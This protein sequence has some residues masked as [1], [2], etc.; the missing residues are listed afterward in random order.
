MDTAD[1]R[2]RELARE[3][4]AKGYPSPRGTGWTHT[5]VYRILTTRAYAG[6]GQWGATAWGDYHQAQGEEIIPTAKTNR[7][8]NNWHR[9]PEEDVIVTAQ[10]HKGIIPVDLFDRVQRKLKHEL[11]EGRVKLRPQTPLSLYGVVERTS[12]PRGR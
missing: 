8:A 6:T 7:K 12:A 3:L 5:N 11:V 1:L 10:A 9:K 2:L 4:T